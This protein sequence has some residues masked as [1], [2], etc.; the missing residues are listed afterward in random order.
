MYVAAEA[1]S[2]LFNLASA[3]KKTSTTLFHI[4]KMPAALCIHCSQRLLLKKLDIGAQLQTSAASQT[5][6]YILYTEQ[7]SRK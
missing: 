2:C 4:E 1:R 5:F 3:A 7:H 6:I